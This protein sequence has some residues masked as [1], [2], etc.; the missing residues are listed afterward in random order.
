MRRPLSRTSTEPRTRA[1]P[2]RATLRLPK[3]PK[4]SGPERVSPWNHA[5][6]LPGAYV[7]PT[8]DITVSGAVTT[9]APVAAY[10]GA[11][12]P[13][14]CFYIERLMDTAARKLGI[15]PAE[16]RRRSSAGSTPS[17]RAAVSIRRSM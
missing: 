2:P 14:A 12:R 1:P 6:L 7:V 3:V 17:V 9:S 8:C 16:L 13:E 15:D 11:G 5:R 10:R 4:P